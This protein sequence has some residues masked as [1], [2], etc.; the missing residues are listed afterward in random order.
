MRPMRGPGF[1]G[2]VHGFLDTLTTQTR[3]DV[4]ALTFARSIR[5]QMEYFFAN[6]SEDAL[7]R[8]GKAVRDEKNA[9]K[10]SISIFSRRF[11]FSPKAMPSR[12]A[13]APTFRRDRS[14]STPRNADLYRFPTLR[15]QSRP[16]NNLT[17][18]PPRRFFS[19][20]NS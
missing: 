3:S 16:P 17:R 5:H 15:R 10:R 1:L 11:V 13:C 7:Y 20:T 4:G 18:G 2:V 8:P 6:L 9:K 12:L 19:T 14:Q